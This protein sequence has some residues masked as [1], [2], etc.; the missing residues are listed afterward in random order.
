MISDFCIPRIV[1]ANMSKPFWV[2]PNQCAAEGGDRNALVS[3]WSY[4]QVT[5]RGLR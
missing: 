5:N 4:C 2:V 1:S 3:S